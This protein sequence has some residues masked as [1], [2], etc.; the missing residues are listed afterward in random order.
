MT[1]NGL[2]QSAATAVPLKLL[3]RLDGAA[4]GS[5][6]DGLRATAPVTLKV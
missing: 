2:T 3:I 1:I 5:G 6:V 4:A